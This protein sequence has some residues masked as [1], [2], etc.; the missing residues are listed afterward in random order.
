MHSTPWDYNQ[1]LA[2]ERLTE[3][4]C[5][6]AGKRA[7]VIDLHNED[8]GDTKLSLGIRAYEC[9]RTK[10]NDVAQSGAYPWLSIITPDGA[11]TFAI[12]GVPVRFVRNDPKCLPDKKIIRSEGASQQLSLFPD[13]PFSDIRWFFVFDTH[14]MSPADAVYFVGYNDRKQIVCQ[15]QVPIDDKVTL[16]HSVS[17][18]LPKAVDLDEPEV[19]LKNA[20]KRG[21]T[22]N[23]R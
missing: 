8:L 6:I 20:S 17:D 2:E 21:I 5:L 10:I 15:W 22:T 18:S 9:C 23:A 16:L 1:G 19:I 12:G 4:A 3:V 13:D 14:Y 7:E 11:F